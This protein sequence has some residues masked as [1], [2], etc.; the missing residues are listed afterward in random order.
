[1]HRTQ[2]YLEE[3]QVTLAKLYAEQEGI[4]FSEFVRR[5][6]DLAIEAKRAHKPIHK[7]GKKGKRP[8]Y[9]LDDLVGAFGIKGGKPT[10]IALNHNDIYDL[11]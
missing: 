6:V 10:N 4:A 8:K 5:G 2:I 9:P 1:M 3:Q 7:K 11:R